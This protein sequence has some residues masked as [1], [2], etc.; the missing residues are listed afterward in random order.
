MEESFV[1]P[2]SMGFTRRRFLHRTLHAGAALAIGYGVARGDDTDP[3]DT[4]R[5]V[6]IWGITQH[7][8]VAGRIV[9]EWMLFNELDLMMQLSKTVARS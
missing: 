5:P 8:I 2:S 3:D 1:S 9:E 6:H 7:K 4:N